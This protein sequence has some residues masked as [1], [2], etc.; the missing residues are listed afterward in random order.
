M[1]LYRFFQIEVQESQ[2]K[3]YCSRDLIALET[4]CFTC[5]LPN[6]IV[7]PEKQPQPSKTSL[8][9]VHADVG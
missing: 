6:L 2:R 1:A 5:P 7:I 4:T 9:Q 3:R 8:G